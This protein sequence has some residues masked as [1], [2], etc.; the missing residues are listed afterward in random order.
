M[1]TSKLKLAGELPLFRSI[2]AFPEG[3][4]GTVLSDAVSGPT[5]VLP[6]PAVPWIVNVALLIHW[7]EPAQLEQAISAAPASNPAGMALF[8]DTDSASHNCIRP[9]L[10]FRTMRKVLAGEAERRKSV[11]PP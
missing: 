11:L 9:F 1:I 3:P 7:L 5:T 8:K 4:A 10:I 6:L 2:S